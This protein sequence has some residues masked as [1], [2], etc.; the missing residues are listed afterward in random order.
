MPSQLVRVPIW[1]GC[2]VRITQRFALLWLS[3]R[4]SSLHVGR[5]SRGSPQ[6]CALHSEKTHD[7]RNP[8]PRPSGALVLRLCRE[9]S[10]S[11]RMTCP[12][13]EALAVYAALRNAPWA[14]VYALAEAGS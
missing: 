11:V 9:R 8:L 6:R 10:R 7:P 12:T 3:R 4:L 1:K 14:L 2:G 13:H 5:P